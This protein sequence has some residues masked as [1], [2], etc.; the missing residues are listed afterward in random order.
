MTDAPTRDPDF[1]SAPPA[2]VAARDDRD[3]RRI[4]ALVKVYTHPA[5]ACPQHEAR[6]G[7]AFL[8]AALGRPP[9]DAA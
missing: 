4:Q 8:R 3:E 1:A 2:G 9:D 7:A 6:V 5:S